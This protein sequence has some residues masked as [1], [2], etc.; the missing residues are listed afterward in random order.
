MP[1]VWSVIAGLFGTIGLVTGSYGAHGL[2]KKTPEQLKTWDSA[3]K[4]HMLHGAVMLL[5][6]PL[7]QYAQQEIVGCCTPSHSRRGW[8]TCIASSRDIYHLINNI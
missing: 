1:P 2:D 8:M 6:L 4:M 3:V 7:T 5:M